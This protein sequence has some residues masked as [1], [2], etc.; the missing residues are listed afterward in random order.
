MV[1]LGDW[2]FV[3]PS[4]VLPSRSSPKTVTIRRIDSSLVPAVPWTS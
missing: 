1:P 4:P 3:L 2:I